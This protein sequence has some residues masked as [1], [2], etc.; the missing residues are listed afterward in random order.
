MMISNFLKE[1]RIKVKLDGKN[2][3]D[4]IK[5]MVD[6]LGISDS[7]LDNKEVLKS[8]IE[9]ENSMSTG[10]GNGIAVP[11]GKCS[12]VKNLVGTLG[13]VKEGIPFD[14]IDGNPVK[15][16][17]MLVAPDTGPSG[18]YIKALSLISKILNN[19]SARKKILNC[20]SPKDIFS[21]LVNEEKRYS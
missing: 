2:K 11:H 16:I 20:N 8:I 5:E 12:S 18:S 9:R 13:I 21:I 3:S 6:L 14:S 17:F 15:I 7:I 1:G 10:I 19:E 4:I